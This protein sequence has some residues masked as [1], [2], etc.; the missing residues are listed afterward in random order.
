M[1]VE[2]G[3]GVSVEAIAVEAGTHGR[4]RGEVTAA[5]AA[6]RLDDVAILLAVPLLR[7]FSP[8]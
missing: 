4:A 8:D 3:T 1:D 5:A 2:T 7:H 6:L